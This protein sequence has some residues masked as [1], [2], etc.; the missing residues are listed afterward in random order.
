MVVF[1]T[2]SFPETQEEIRRKGIPV[3]THIVKKDEY[4][5]VKELFYTEKIHVCNYPFVIDELKNLRIYRG[6]RVDHPPGGSKDTCDALANNVWAQQEL[7]G[8]PTIPLIP[9]MAV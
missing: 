7:F 9:G 8:M 2:W 4:D 3:M 1:D 6:K 5:K